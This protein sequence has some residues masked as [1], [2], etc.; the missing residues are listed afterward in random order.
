M[1]TLCKLSRCAIRA[2]HD[3]HAIS[4][5]ECR[6]TK[7][8]VQYSVKPPVRVPQI[9]QYHRSICYFNELLTIPPWP[10]KITFTSNLGKTGYRE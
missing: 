9:S 6:I 2:D 5:I 1:S 4:N 3:V 10:I 8:S 7:S